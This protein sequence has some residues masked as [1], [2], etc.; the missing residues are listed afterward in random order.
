MVLTEGATSRPVVSKYAVPLT[1]PVVRLMVPAD[2]AK[3]PAVP[4]TSRSV[5]PPA[6]SHWVPLQNTMRLATLS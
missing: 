5:V 6:A 1:P 2:V 3:T 4:L